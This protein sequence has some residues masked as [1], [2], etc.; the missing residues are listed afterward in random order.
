MSLLKQKLSNLLN[1]VSQRPQEQRL[2]SQAQTQKNGLSSVAR[3]LMKRP[4]LIHLGLLEA[5]ITGWNNSFIHTINR[6]E[7]ER[8]HVVIADGEVFVYD[9]LTFTPVTVLAPGGFGYLVDTGKG[10]RATTAGDTT[11]IVNRGKTVRQGS[12]KFANLRHEALVYFRQGDFGTTYTTTLNGVAVSIS[13]AVAT[14]ASTRALISTDKLAADMFSALYGDPLVNTGDFTF[15]L[16]GSCIHI[17]RTDGQDFEL[18]ASDGLGESG[19]KVVKGSLQSFTDLPR[20]AVHGF[21]VQITGDPESDNDNYWVRYDDGKVRRNGGPAFELAGT[22]GHEGVWRECPAPGTVVD[23]NATTMP[24]RLVRYGHVLSPLTP[25]GNPLAHVTVTGVPTAL[26]V[27]V[28]SPATTDDWEVTTPGDVAIDAAVNNIEL[29]DHETGIKLTTVATC[30]F[31]SIVYSLDASLCESGNDVT[32]KAY[33]NGVEQYS[34]V[35][36]SG[37]GPIYWQPARDENGDPLPWNPGESTPLPGGGLIAISGGVASG[38]V[39]EVKMFYAKNDT[40]DT[41][42]RAFFSTSRTVSLVSTPEREVRFSDVDTYPVGTEIDVDIDG[43]VFTYTVAASAKTGAQIATSLSATIN[44]HANFVA[45]VGSTPESIKI[46]RANNAQFVVVASSVF[47][48]AV[49][50]YNPELA[51]VANEHAGRVLKNVTDGSSGTITSNDVQVITVGAL[52]GGV[53]NIFQAGDI[54][55]VEGTGRYFVFQPCPWEQRKAGDLTV[56]PFPS[57]TNQTIGDVVFY[58][59]RLGFISNENVVFSEVGNLFRFFRISAAQLFDSDVIDVKAAHREIALFHSFVL[60]NEE[61]YAISDNGEFSISGEPALAPAT[62]RIDL[63][64]NVP[65]TP[66]PRPL[67]AGNKLYLT[68][69]KGGFTSVQEFSVQ[70]NTTG[71]PKVENTDITKEVPRYIKGT[72]LAIAGDETVGF[73]AVLTNDAGAKSLYVYSYY[74]GDDDH[75]RLQASWSKWDF[76]DGQ[77]VGIDMVDG[78]L[79]IVSVHANGVFISYLDMNVAINTVDPDEGAQYLDRRLTELTAGVTVG[80]SGGNTTWTLPYQVATDGSQGTLMVVLRSPLTILATTR[81]ASNQIRAVGDYRTLPVYIGVQYEFRY[82]LSRLFFRDSNETPETNGR[83]ALKFLDV[84]YRDTTG[85]DVVVTPVGRSARTLTVAF[86][87][88]T[89]GQTRVAIQSENKQTDIELV[90][91]TPGVCSFTSVD[92]EGYFSQRDKRV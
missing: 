69:G 72:P 81:P 27:D 50:F 92:W 64:A 83:L 51:M 59:N 37:V 74:F 85:F 48:E 63:V 39:I 23:F 86:A 75:K 15:T 30:D 10:F 76:A 17:Y 58:Q 61:L 56:C 4:P 20:M 5:D 22:P 73:L 68:R 40:P 12:T 26:V 13:T 80:F 32:V 67:V 14:A 71:D 47:N 90:N 8:Y 54:I 31:L 91:S 77:I 87:L 82:K 35:H 21:V 2:S 52:T 49:K 88:P 79:G 7:T 62:I 43:S 24:H 9:A 70:S 16:I 25:S 57:F 18:T 38:S 19:L 34:V 6:D 3:G 1:G 36:T 33:K 11:V 42:R 89:E 46:S 66:G 55:K 28:S 41:F 29:R 44:A 45:A 60:W 78:K 53:D 65:N 84:F